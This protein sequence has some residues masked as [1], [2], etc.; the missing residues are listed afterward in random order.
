[1]PDVVLD[2]NILA[3]LLAQFFGSAQRGR[4]P[5]ARQDTITPE[6]ARKINQIVRWH[7]WDWELENDQ[8]RHPGLIVAATFAFVE[9]ARKWTDIVRERFTVEQMAGFIEQ[10]PEWFVIEPVDENLVEAFCD[11]PTDIRTAQGK[12]RSLEWPDAI[13]IAVAFGRGDDCLLAAT[14]SEIR[15]IEV[16]QNRLI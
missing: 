5:F 3:D 10:P 14:D 6:L 16:L 15:R 9:I 2:T 12:M 13:H 11:V 4:A 1:M 7:T 8:A